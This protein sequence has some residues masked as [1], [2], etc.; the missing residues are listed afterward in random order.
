MRKRSFAGFLVLKTLALIVL[1]FPLYPVFSLFD[2]LLPKV[3]ELPIDTLHAKLPLTQLL[4]AELAAFWSILAVFLSNLLRKF[5]KGPFRY[6]RVCSLLQWG[7]AFAPIV[8]LW[9]N[10]DLSVLQNW[11]TLIGML[12]SSI[13]VGARCQNSYGEILPEKLWLITLITNLVVLLGI[14]MMQVDYDAMSYVWIY[15][16]YIIIFYLITNQSNIDYLMDRRKHRR[17]DLPL[18]IRRYNFF[19]VLAV[20]G[21]VLVGFLLKDVWVWLFESFFDL[22]QY[23]IY[24]FVYGVIWLSSRIFR[25]GGDAVIDTSGGLEDIGEAPQHREAFWWTDFVF[26]GALIAIILFF[27]INNRRAI[28]DGL[29]NM[30][31]KLQKLFAALIER[32][33]DALKLQMV[34]TGEAAYYVD[35]I[36]MISAQDVKD[37]LRAQ[38][39]LM[40]DWKKQY[41]RFLAMPDDAEKLRFGYQLSLEWVLLR[42]GSFSEAETPL[43][44]IKSVGHYLPRD[45]WTQVTENYQLIRYGELTEQLAGMQALVKMLAG[46]L[47]T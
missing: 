15:F 10:F 16:G 13:I 7:F 29:R 25:I 36:E 1:I 26:Y 27:V 9:F 17:A 41:K 3:L 8:W 32:V 20:F 40:R 46:L 47:K 14:W 33:R 23:G 4:L 35:D 22:L 24:W 45:A 28:F 6:E 21:V 30:L 2:V 31:M 43:E 5:R 38:R 37:E 18:K 19:M 42:G 34:E 12:L 39:F 44:R 11:V